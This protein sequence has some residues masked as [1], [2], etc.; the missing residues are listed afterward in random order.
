[1]YAARKTHSAPIWRSSDTFHTASNGVRKSLAKTARSSVG[2]TN[3]ASGPGT[4][5]PY[6]SGN[7]LGTPALPNGSSN[8][9]PSKE[10]P[11]ANGA[12]F[13]NGLNALAWIGVKKWPKLP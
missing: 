1:M 10:N 12:M 4:R 6:C 5:G 3:V 13:G 2:V 7:G 11:G 8:D 9:T